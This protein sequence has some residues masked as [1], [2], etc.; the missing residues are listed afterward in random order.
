M[1]QEFFGRKIGN[2]RRAIRQ[3]L[4][5][6]IGIFDL[7]VAQF[8]VL[9]RL[10]D[11][12]NLGTLQLAKE[13]GLDTGT[14]TGVVDRLEQKGLVRR[15]RNTQ[16]RRAVQVLLTPAGEELQEPLYGILQEVN[17][18]ALSGL[19][20]EVRDEMMRLLDLVVANL[21]A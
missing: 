18:K 10:Y 6:R 17:E 11:H 5:S 15:E 8:Q 1:P 19:A 13:T 21:N 3:Q 2:V 20:P 16:D 4:E 12:N 14:I 9:R 7:T